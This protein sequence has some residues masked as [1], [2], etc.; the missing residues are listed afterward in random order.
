MNIVGAGL[1]KLLKITPVSLTEDEVNGE[2]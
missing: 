1:Y 2:G